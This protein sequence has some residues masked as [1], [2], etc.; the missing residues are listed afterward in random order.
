MARMSPEYFRRSM[1]LERFR[2]NVMLRMKLM[3]Y[4]GPLQNFHATKRSTPRC[5]SGR[6]AR[7]REIQARSD[8]LSVELRKFLQMGLHATTTSYSSSPDEARLRPRIPGPS[9]GYGGY[10]QV[11]SANEGSVSGSPGAEE[12]YKHS[13]SATLVDFFHWGHCRSSRRGLSDEYQPAR[14]IGLRF[15]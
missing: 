5:R 3:Y 12:L 4:E 11:G 15:L 9:S 8:E 7:Y 10:I 13:P 2:A 14:R 6:N 1:S